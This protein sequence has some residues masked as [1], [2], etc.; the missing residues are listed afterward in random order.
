MTNRI[1]PDAF[2][3]YVALGPGRSYRAV[4]ER[5][6]VSKRAVTK[7]AVKDKWA[8]R[9]DKIEAEAREKSDKR[10]IES[11]EEMRSRH[12]KTLRAIHSRALSALKQY[13]LTSG[14]EAIRAAEL[15]I[16]LERLV[17]GEPT[18]RSALSV[19]EVTRREIQNLLTVEDGDDDDEWEA[20]PA[21]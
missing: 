1:P 17:V 6:G 9:L 13:P 10:L 21:G 4:A 12:I 8:E 3:W 7:H 2:D 11:I 5:Y 16:K 14:M 15:A 19:E 18:E 20:A